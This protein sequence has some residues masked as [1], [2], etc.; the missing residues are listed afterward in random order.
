LRRCFEATSFSERFGELEIDK[1]RFASA[2]SMTASIN[3]K[4]AI[5]QKVKD[6]VFRRDQGRCV[7][8]GKNNKLSFHHLENRFEG[9]A[10]D[11]SK[12]V[13]LCITCHS[14]YHLNEIEILGN[15]TEGFTINYFPSRVDT[16]TNHLYRTKR[17]AY[18]ESK[19]LKA[20]FDKGQNLLLF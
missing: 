19:N 7:C 20:S 12:I 16:I 14:L 9:G 5:P 6:Y 15:E 8:C 13:L 4:K 10:H 2:C 11:P 18:L 1:K 17:R 3:K